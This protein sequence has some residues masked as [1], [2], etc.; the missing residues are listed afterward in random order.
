MKSSMQP[1]IA[2]S[3]HLLDQSAQAL[4]S[5]ETD[6]QLNISERKAL[7]EM[8]LLADLLR[9]AVQRQLILDELWQVCRREL[10][11]AVRQ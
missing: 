1:A 4:K 9:N 11:D 3:H 8:L 2:A 10:A 5:L 6:T 7:G